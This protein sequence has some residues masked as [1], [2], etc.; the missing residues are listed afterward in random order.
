MDTGGQQEIGLCPLVHTCVM[1]KKKHFP[2]KEALYGTSTNTLSRQFFFKRFIIISMHLLG[3]PLPFS[4]YSVSLS[5]SLSTTSNE[6]SV[7]IE[8]PISKRKR[9][10]CVLTETSNLQWFFLCSEKNH[11]VPLRS[12]PF[13]RSRH[14]NLPKHQF[15]FYS[16]SSATEQCL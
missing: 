5:L 15:H 11:C 3:W 14:P 16:S 1:W 12:G 6:F 10:L 7:S 9:E 4:I 2:P 8:L 13:F